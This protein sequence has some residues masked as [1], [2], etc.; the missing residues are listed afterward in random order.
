MINIENLGKL[1]VFVVA[2]DNHKPVQGVRVTLSAT[3]AGS[4]ST[5]QLPL[6]TLLTDQAGYASFSIARIIARGMTTVADLAVE[7]DGD[8]SSRV[9]ISVWLGLTQSAGSTLEAS[10][11]P[12]PQ[13]HLGCVALTLTTKR[14]NDNPDSDCA[15][16]SSANGISIQDPDSCDYEL[17]PSSLVMCSTVKTGDGD[18]ERI[19]PAKLPVSRYLFREVVIRS[20]KPDKPGRNTTRGPDSFNSA[21]IDG[22]QPV[23]L[24][25]ISSNP[26][27]S[28]AETT[29]GSAIAARSGL[30]FGEVL[31]YEQTWF[32]LGHALG[33]IKYSLTLAPGEATQVAVI[34]WS[35]SDSVSRFDAVSLADRLKHKQDFD[36]QIDET[37]NAALSEDQGGGSFEG[38]LGAAASGAAGP[39]NLGG[40]LSLGGAVTHT[41]GDRD[42]AA[43]SQQDIHAKV[44][45]S[46]TLR[47]SLTS[48]VVIQATQGESNTLST[49]AIANHNHCHSLT[50]LYYEVLRHLRVH[51]ALRSRRWVVCIPFSF[52]NFELNENILR[53]RVALE[54][55]LLDP[56]RAIGFDALERLNSMDY[57]DWPDSS[58]GQQGANGFGATNSGTT[59]NSDPGST[60]SPMIAVQQFEITLRTTTWNW[61]TTWG[62]IVVEIANKATGSWVNIW[63]K[64]DVSDHGPE[65]NKITFPQTVPAKDWNAEDLGSVRV[66]WRESN[67]N[68]SWDFKGITIKCSLSD[69]TVFKLV[70][71]DGDTVQP[72]SKSN[73][74]AICFFDDSQNLIFSPSIAGAMYKPVSGTNTTAPASSSTLPANERAELASA[75]E[76]ADKGAIERLR[77]H[78]VSNTGYYSRMVWM[79]M[80][81]SERRDL[82]EAA[83]ANSPALLN[84]ID[85]R[86]LGVSGNRV[87]FAFEG[88]PPAW[89]AA[90]DR[91]TPAP[92]E[93]I[94]TFPTPGLFAE[95]QLGHCNA[96]EK[97]DVTRMWN[98]AEMPVE[99]LPQMSDLSPGPRGQTPSVDAAQLPANVL[100][101]VS[102]PTVPDPTGL[103]AAIT[104]ISKGDS[105]RD[106]SGLAQVSDLLGKLSSG[107][108]DLV[109]GQQGLQ[110]AAA[111]AK[112]KVDAA[113]GSDT[114]KQPTSDTKG[115]SASDLADRFSLVPDIKN[116]GKEFRL[117]PDELKQFAIDKINGTNP[118]SVPAPKST[119]KNTKLTPVEIKLRCFVPSELISMN[120]AP[121]PLAEVTE[122]LFLGN[123]RD[124]DYSKGNSI[125]E[126]KA[127]F[128]LDLDQMTVF[129]FNTKVSF[130]MYE[131]FLRTDGTHTSNKPHWWFEKSDPNA[132]P[133]SG[134]TGHVPVDDKLIKVEV[135]DSGSSIKTRLV[136][137]ANPFM[138]SDIRYLDIVRNIPLVGGVVAASFEALLGLSPD[139][140]LELVVT[141]SKR[142]D[143][144]ALFTV[145][146]RHDGFPSYELYVN[147]ADA[148]R[149]SAETSSPSSLLGSGDITVSDPN[150]HL[151]EPMPQP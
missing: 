123:N 89:L 32:G 73:E 119:G 147:H 14:S 7:I 130:G 25:T 102:A 58:N 120:M 140:D 1:R 150:L 79:Y 53:F 62:E 94:V 148:Y 129:D 78:L 137:H 13:P 3:I 143:G 107:A 6:A 76:E 151:L 124:F 18:C 15:C 70:D 100:N 10:N 4:T 131:W 57:Y 149:F 142:E 49:R 116:F 109:K 118:P 68:D 50:I 27:G 141:I 52:V 12:P 125:A 105:F 56:R 35:R 134:L 45:Q 80:D 39:V 108:V 31:E 112:Q 139:I 77:N 59:N 144:V 22:F 87:A 115:P 17:S 113:M 71:K 65:L 88:D 96:C 84:S 20:A 41:W 37:V 24:L 54:P 114:N 44:V 33:E 23:D 36:R 8:Q 128:Q 81:P 5:T 60:G 47:R 29:D 110:Q 121:G 83:L 92:V 95:A 11:L 55:N 101:V 145:S 133:I 43:D 28:L 82:L 126:I 103:A 34:D 74:K 66:G 104:A 16:G 46:S 91:E 75:R 72:N 9:S 40:V 21:W 38:G 132:T 136:I 2:S 19:A 63:S 135:D 90:L 42:L 97:R 61:G 117:N 127:T 64:S 67:N 93:S 106:M 122:T 30:R 48:T 99:Q 69:G 51:T 98:W 86:P 85:D 146:G 26:A 111:A 138:S